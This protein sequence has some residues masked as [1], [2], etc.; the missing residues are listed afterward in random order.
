MR[1][2]GDVE[3]MDTTL[4][5]LARGE[6]ALRL[7]LGQLLEILGRG[8]VFDLGFSSLGAYAVERCERSVRWVEAARCLARRVEALPELRRA[9]ATGDVSW[10]LAEVLA[11]VATPADESRWLALAEGRTVRQV[12]LL[13]D[14]A[15]SA[16]RA[17]VATRTKARSVAL[18][19]RVGTGRAR[20]AGGGHVAGGGL[21]G[22]VGGGGVGG[23]GVGGGGV[24]ASGS[25]DVASGDVAC[26]TLSGGVSCGDAAD[27]ADELV[28]LTCTVD[29]E[30]AWLFEA[31]RC[32]LEQLGERS[33]PGQ[34]EA[35][36]AEA[37][38]TLL[39]LLPRGAI[40]A[41]CLQQR[42]VA[43]LRR[44]ERLRRWQAEAEVSC[45]RSVLTS[46][47]S[48][49][50]PSVAPSTSS[51]RVALA[52]SLGMAPF[53]QTS[54]S[55][56]DRQVRIV[57]EALARHELELS[58]LVLR[59]HRAGG[60]RKLGYATETQ[61]ARERLGLSRSSFVA[62]RALALRLERLPGV[63]AALGAAHIGVEAA[64][65][66][67]RVATPSTEA[68]W[69]DRARRRTIKHLREEVAAALVAVRWAGDVDC[70]PPED[71]ELAAFQALE[72]AVVSGRFGRPSVGRPSVGHPSAA[73]PSV[74]DPS[75]GDPS[76]G[77]PAATEG[78]V[79]PK[80]A[81]TSAPFASARPLDDRVTGPRKAWCV[82]LASLGSWLRGGV[83]MSAAAPGAA[84]SGRCS[85]AGR[86]TLRLRV[87]RETAAWWR[88]LEAQARRWLPR[89][90]SWLRFVCLSVWQGWGHLLGARGAYGHIYI[91][92]RFRC[93]SPVCTRG[94]VTPHHIQFRSAGG[95]DDASNVTSPCS[96]CHLYGV[97]GG[98]IRASGTADHIRWELGPKNEPSLIVDGRERLPQRG[99]SSVK[100]R[101]SMWMSTV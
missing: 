94:D 55:G 13:V 85:H 58:E 83:Q 39:A 17:A 66:L 70:P 79:D 57:A 86:V 60:W 40:E 56:L 64:L 29:R 27:D 98:R 49:S 1:G 96:W 47:A 11:R 21:G 7:R 24:D 65:Q 95:S 26:G 93:T 22:G 88:G 35:M 48:G 77:R 63:A 67:V 80:G 46:L 44:V 12:R 31:T 92:D 8:A 90:E 23:G 84:A 75:V 9:M 33:A 18:E 41:D 10:A 15:V 81:C 5:S 37:Q 51:G 2:F 54:C 19:Q 45:E 74:G 101:S 99:P 50:R 82:M 28:T 52:A 20:E 38:S 97:H 4:A 16:A 32:L 59:L 91:R 71:A 14:D 43:Q 25:G 69:I 68:A 34:A 30:D 62:R 36:L 53:A 6:C 76:V 89:G 42:D 73:R 61:Y 78:R 3:C 72:Q 100:R 87:S